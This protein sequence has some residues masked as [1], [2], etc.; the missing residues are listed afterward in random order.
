VFN[1][2]FDPS[3]LEY[4]ASYD[5]S[6]DASPTFAI[7]VD[8]LIERLVRHSE[9]RHGR[10]IEVG[11]G[12]GEFLRRLFER[13]D[14]TGEGIG[15]DPAYEGPLLLHGGRLQF[16][17][18]FYEVA[19][20]ADALV[21]RHVIEHVDDPVRL[22]STISSGK[23]SA[24]V[25]IETPDVEWI[26]RHRVPWDFFYEH[27][28]LFSATSLTFALR[29]AGS[30]SIAVERRFGNQY[31]WAEAT[32]GR[33][34]NVIAPERPEP[35]LGGSFDFQELMTCLSDLVG[36][37]IERGPTFVW[38]AG[39]KG[40]TFCGMVDDDGSRLAGVI[41]I[42]SAKHGRF[43]AGTGHPIVSP[44]D[45][46]THDMAVAIV[47]NPV[48]KGEISAH[49]TSLGSNASVVDAMQEISACA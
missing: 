20:P 21:C 42:N 27:C 40:V 8:Q 49:L 26:T 39:A 31:L 30:S 7:H 35:A 4:G 37:L 13:A 6:Q 2:A 33:G 15:F 34:E 44:K 11:C 43:V 1:A 10:V 25:F 22:L 23:E 5:N 32:G 12:K 24:L 3:L 9:I 41:D 45:A 47:L 29:R 38:G 17:R 14:V 46:V 18:R 48:Y 19:V 36:R 16:K 28:S